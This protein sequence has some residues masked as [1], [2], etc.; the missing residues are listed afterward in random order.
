MSNRF[1]FWSK[2]LLVEGE[3]RHLIELVETIR[4]ATESGFEPTNAITDLAYSIEYELGL[5][6]N[7]ED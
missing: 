6:G 5:V 2:S 3:E 4:A 7:G 1:R